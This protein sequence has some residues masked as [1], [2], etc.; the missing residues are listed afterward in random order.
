MSAHLL[1]LDEKPV[2]DLNHVHF[3][4]LHGG[5]LV[6]GTWY[7]DRETRQSEPC[8]VLLDAARRVQRK[9]TI[10]CVIRLENMWRWAPAP[11]GDPEHIS[12]HIYGW[13]SSGAL[14]GSAT[15][16]KDVFNVLSA[17]HSRLRD[18]WSMPPLPM[19]AAIKNGAVPIGTLSVTERDTGKTVQE[20]EVVSSNV[21][22]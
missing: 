13:L 6:I 1:S 19:K 16:K 10:P 17:V 22:N 5:I 21:R 4:A 3:E 12:Q 2:L 7:M 9:K 15:N 11:M 18:L 14:P 20:I 8:L